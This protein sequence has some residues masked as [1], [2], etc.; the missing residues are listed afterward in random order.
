MMRVTYYFLWCIMNN[1]EYILDE[2]TDT[3][4]LCAK[5]LSIRIYFMSF[6]F[7]QL[8]NMCLISIATWFL[9]YLQ[10]VICQCLCP[11]RP[12]LPESGLER[13]WEKGDTQIPVVWINKLG[14]KEFVAWPNT[15]NVECH[16]I[17]RTKPEKDWQFYRVV[18]RKQYSG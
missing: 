5:L 6:Q 9:C 8:W 11:S 16:I 2:R 7:Y 10:N 13:E 18:M 14:Q 15:Q 1:P 17:Q 4:L 3:G 12:T